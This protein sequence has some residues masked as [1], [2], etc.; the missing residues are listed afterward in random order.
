LRYFSP[1]P[2]KYVGGTGYSWA[3]R[4]SLNG[5]EVGEVKDYQRLGQQSWE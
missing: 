4:Y 5:L 1:P 3:D 2:K